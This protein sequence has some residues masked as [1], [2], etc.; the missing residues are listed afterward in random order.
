MTSNDLRVTPKE[1]SPIIETVKP[2]TAK[3][4]KLKSGS[5]MENQEINDEFLDEIL[6]NKDL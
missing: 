6:H 3:K 2:N 4:N 1:S 5:F